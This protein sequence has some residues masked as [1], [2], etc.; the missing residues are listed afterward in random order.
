MKARYDISS[1]ESFA[2]WEQTPTVKRNL[3][4]GRLESVYSFGIKE[5]C[6]KVEVT[7]MW[8]PQQ[9]LPVWGLSIRHLEW[10][11]HL[12]ELESLPVGR[13][14]EWGDT[15][16]SFFPADGQS[17]SYGDLGRDDLGMTSLKLDDNSRP[18]PRDGMENLVYHLLRLS[19]IVSSVTA[20]G[21]VQSAPEDDNE[22]DVDQQSW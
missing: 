13:R 12:A 22:E 19:D 17:P 4:T 11:T 21:G 3:F 14:A 16:P 15:I 7:A 2:E 8:Y 6:Y 9:K 5:T 20:E 18:P 1:T 10:A